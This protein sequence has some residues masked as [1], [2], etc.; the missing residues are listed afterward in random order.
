MKF[1]VLAIATLS[2]VLLPLAHGQLTGPLYSNIPFEFRVGNTVLPPGEYN[3]SPTS[4][5]GAPQLVVVRNLD[6]K[7]PAIM[8]V[9]AR[10]APNAA[11]ELVFRQYG[12]TYFLTRVSPGLGWGGLELGQSKAE[13]VMRAEIAARAAPRLPVLASVPLHR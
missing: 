5:F 3:F 4:L 7:A 2:G 6:R 13:R 9:T 8:F 11:C 1:K 12:K 10:G